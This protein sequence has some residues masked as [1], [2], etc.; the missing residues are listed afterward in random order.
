MPYTPE[1]IKERYDTLPIDIR[2]AIDSVDTT[3]AVVDIGQK[4]DLM[5]DQISEL[6]DEVGLVMVGLTPSARFVNNLAR[7]MQVDMGEAMLIAQ[8]INK[9]VFDKLRESLKN[10]EAGRNV[11]EYETSGDGATKKPQPELSEKTMSTDAEKIQKNSVISAVEKAGGFV[12]DKQEEAPFEAERMVRNSIIERLGPKKDIASVIKRESAPVTA[13]KIES[14]MPTE[15]LLGDTP[16]PTGETPVETTNEKIVAET[17]PQ[18]TV[19]SAEKIPTQ[20]QDSIVDTLLSKGVAMSMDQ[21]AP[22]QDKAKPYDGTDPYR[23]PIQ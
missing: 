14:S 23:E 22:K 11:N 5:Y 15:L 10:I 20:G 2:Q 9:G 6:V 12:I 1:Q 17:V 18:T 7:R 16:E 4:Y 8:D 21:E 19:E 3:N 13:A